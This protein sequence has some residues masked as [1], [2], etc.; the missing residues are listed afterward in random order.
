MIDPASPDFVRTPAASGRPSFSYAPI[1][2]DALPSLTII[3]PFFNTDPAIFEETARSIRRQSLQQWE[4]L[5]VDDG[6]SRSDSLDVLRQLPQGDPRIK[7]IHHARNRGLPAARNTAVKH[8]R[9]DFILQLDSDDLLEPTAAEKW[10]WFLTSHPEYAFV[11]GFGVGFGA[12]EYLWTR[13]FHDRDGF[14]SENLVSA[15]SLIRRQVFDSVGGYD[16]AIGDGLED[17]EFWLRCAAAGLWGGTVPEYLDWYR[18]RAGDSERWRSWDGGA[19][20]KELLKMCRQ[21]YPHLWKDDGFPRI[22]PVAPP[23]SEIALEKV[24]C[25]NLLTKKTPRLLFLV[26]WATVGGADKF[27][28]DLVAQMNRQG[29]QTTIATTLGGDHSWLPQLEQLTPDVFAL[30]RFLKHADYPRFLRYLIHSRQPDVVLIGNSLFAYEALPYLRLAANGIPI[31]DYCHMEEDYWLDGGYPRKSVEHRASLDL[32]ITSSEYLKNWMAEQGA[33]RER[34]EVSYTNID[35]R[36]T[37]RQPT[38]AMLGFPEGVPLLV[39]ACRVTEQKQPAIF[40]K[41]LRELRRQDQPFL[42]LVVGEGPYLQWLRRFTR[43]NG[44]RR[45]VRFLGSVP[46]TRVRE[47]MAVADCVFLPSKHEGIA[48]TL[49]EAMAE[50]V[51]VVAADVGGQR[52]LVTPDSGVLLERGGDEPARYAGV[53]AALLA[54]PERRRMMGEAGQARIRDGFTLVLMGARMRSLLEHAGELAR[55]APRSSPTKEQAREAAIKAVRL[56]ARTS[57]PA[58]YR[59]ES[60]PSRTRLV[61]LRWVKAGGTPLY[62]LSLRLGFHWAEAVKQRVERLLSRG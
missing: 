14:L 48:L 38:R 50:G 53:L 31:V 16:E 26:P 1:R 28:I 19:R 44:L 24:P 22:K 30:H 37:S 15:T 34:I 45:H 39:Y 56:A 49:Y 51:P 18:R 54:D 21:R 60:L 23:E 52:E 20:Q 62:E 47:L 57:V 7:V 27:N 43:R 33:D 41:A 25:D 13:G 36:D 42:A 46:N 10:L 32:Q 8:A 9:T 40:A 12:Q 11:K 17:W 58:V 29:W 61:L 6:S 5:V 59:S 3:T 35:L 55:S 4:W 2:A